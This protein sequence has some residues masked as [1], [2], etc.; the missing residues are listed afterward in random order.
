VEQLIL[1]LLQKSADHS[2][3]AQGLKPAK[4]DFNH[5]ALVGGLLSSSRAHEEVESKGILTTEAELHGNLLVA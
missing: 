5:Q 4:V 2:S 3:P 1:I